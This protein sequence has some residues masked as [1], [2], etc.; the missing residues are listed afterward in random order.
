[1]QPS[2]RPESPKPTHKR[3]PLSTAFYSDAVLTADIRGDGDD[4]QNARCAQQELGRGGAGDAHPTNQVPP[5]PRPLIPE[6][7]TRWP[8]RASRTWG[9]WAQGRAAH[10]EKAAMR[11]EN[12]GVFE[13]A[14]FP[15]AEEPA[16]RLGSPAARGDTGTREGYRYRFSLPEYKPDVSRW[17]PPKRSGRGWS[18]FSMQVTPSRGKSGSEAAVPAAMWRHPCNPDFTPQRFWKILEEFR[19]PLMC[20]KEDDTVLPA[21]LPQIVPKLNLSF[22]PNAAQPWLGQD[23]DREGRH[24]EHM[25]A[26]GKTGRNRL[27]RHRNRELAEPGSFPLGSPEDNMT[28]G[29]RNSWSSFTS[30]QRHQHFSSFVATD[31]E[32]MNLQ[33]RKLGIKPLG[34]EWDLR[35]TLQAQDRTLQVAQ[36]AAGAMANQNLEVRP[37][38]C[39]SSPTRGF[40]YAVLGI[41]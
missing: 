11:T 22:L 40:T 29:Q 14:S 19:Q 21:S 20:N 10:G 4:K 18:Q 8:P 32:L 37:C 26:L 25:P 34:A 6:G 12:N 30:L 17:S 3:A 35:G 33:H 28:N 39:L 15:P 1:M 9:R 7:V 27:Q 23:E 41:V 16:S 31:K 24:H 5:Q 13:R 36:V 2:H 38:P